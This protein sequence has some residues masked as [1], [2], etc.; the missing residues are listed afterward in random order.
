M[1]EQHLRF[2][3]F[4]LVYEDGFVRYISYGDAEILRKIYFA[5][6]D[7]N[8]VTID[9][10]VTNH[11]LVDTGS[12]FRITYTATNHVAGKNVF[13]WNVE[14]IGTSDGRLTFEVDGIALAA[15][16]RNRAG[17][18][19]LHT[20]PGSEVVITRPDGSTYQTYFAR[21]VS[22]HQPYLNIRKFEWETVGQVR[23]QLEFE[24]DVFETEDQ[25]NWSDASFKTYSTPLSVP[26]PVTLKAGD[27][28]RQKVTFS[29]QDTG[30][31]KKHEI[32]VV[33]VFYYDDKF[34]FPSIGADFGGRKL[35]EPGDVQQLTHLKFDHL[36]IELDL[37]KADWHSKLKDGVAEAKSISAD[38]F[39][40]LVLGTSFE[41][42][43]KE[44]RGR[45]DSSILASVKAVAISPSDRKANMQLLL[46]H[47]L[48]RVTQLFP[49]AKIGAG[50]TSY[51]T[52]LNR[53]RFDYSG[54]DFVTYS[55]NPQVHAKDTNTII[56][57]LPAQ[58]DVVQSALALSNQTPVRVGPVTLRPRFN[59]DAKP[60]S[61]VEEAG[62]PYKYDPR[63]ASKMAAGWMLASIGYLAEGGAESLTL[64]ESHGMAGYFLAN[65]D[66]AHRDFAYD[67]KVFPVYEAMRKLK[68]LS[69]RY[70]LRTSS[71]I[72]RYVT[73]LVV[74]GDTGK[75]VILINHRNT[76]VKVT[77]P[78]GIV[79]LDPYEYR[80]IPQ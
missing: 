26:Y 17:I 78:Q 13:R 19:V 18:C 16:T 79:E 59:P 76:N 25:R 21:E 44:F 41:E 27:K 48:P 33:N 39:L 34:T 9:F 63:Q 23:A 4:D 11:Q 62:L 6:R 60:G 3:L 7:S 58:L 2:G 73:A 45:I 47:M 56:E 50:F 36:R 38:V 5:L 12:G 42:Q 28:V 51:F 35:A 30:L 72:P 1:A 80:F 67:H 20:L 53:N 57:N 69:P 71:R 77:G 14:I 74:E 65:G 10:D 22:P 52:E 37:Q 49:G 40:H 68:E 55:S 75:T 43:W 24:G 15:F 31:P 54:L 70:V 61:E 32:G 46:D 8:W 29:I 66:E 64:L